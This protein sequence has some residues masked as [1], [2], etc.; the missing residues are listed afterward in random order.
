MVSVVNELQS[1]NE[2]VP[3]SCR[4]VPQFILLSELQPDREGVLL[5][6]R[7]GVLLALCGRGHFLNDS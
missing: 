7:V 6:M 5:G 2:D 1:L 3:I 4:L